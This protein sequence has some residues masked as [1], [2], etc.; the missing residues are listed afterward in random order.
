[1][2]PPPRISRWSGTLSS[3]IMDVESRAGTSSRP[4]IRG[5]TGREPVLMKICSPF[6]RR[7]VSPST[8]TPGPELLHYGALARPHLLHVDVH[9]PGL[10]PVVRRPPGQISDT[11][12]GHHGLGGGATPVHARS[13]NVSLFHDGRLAPRSG[14]SHGQRHPTLPGSNDYRLELLSIAHS[15]LPPVRVEFHRN[16]QYS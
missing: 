5:E 12:A 16:S 7:T 13:A 14:Q 6:R 9:R 11:R 8:L 3:S 2:Y 10:H 1:M 15:L 4:E